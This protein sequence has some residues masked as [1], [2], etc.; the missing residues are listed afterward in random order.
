MQ[1]TSVSMRNLLLLLAVRD[2]FDTPVAQY[3]PFVL[4]VPLNTN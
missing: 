2:T 3:S 1:P 4:K